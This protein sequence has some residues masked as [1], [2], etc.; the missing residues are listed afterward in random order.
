LAV[1]V[2][3]REI[4]FGRLVHA[5]AESFDLVDVCCPWQQPVELVSTSLLPF[6]RERKRSKKCRD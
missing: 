3:E 2:T 1:V 5:A 6:T 4:I